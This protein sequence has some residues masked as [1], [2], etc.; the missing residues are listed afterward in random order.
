MCKALEEIRAMGKE[1]G[2][3]EGRAE[4]EVCGKAQEIVE[5]AKELGWSS[6][7]ILQ[8]L[9]EKLHISPEKAQEYLNQYP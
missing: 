5:F 1:E 8:R 6:E 2:R 4:G 3:V 7:Q 9:Q